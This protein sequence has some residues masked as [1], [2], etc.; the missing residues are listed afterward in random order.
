MNEPSSRSRGRPRSIDRTAALDAAVEA[1]WVRGYDGAS[2]TDLTT[3]MALSRPSLYAAYGDKSDLFAAALDRYLET[4]GGAP[5]RAFEA[6]ADDAA[7]VR[8]FLATSAEGNT[9]PGASQGCL[10]A[11]CAAT[12][13]G[14]DAGLRAKLG[15]MMTATRAR[16]AV[17]LGEVRAGLLLDMMN[18]QAVMART[19]AGRHAVLRDLDARV[20]AVME[21]G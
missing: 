5:M 12:A 21:A 17:R 15:A 20:R 6:E 1:F 4:I 7:A 9:R 16:L 8:A 13:A 10:I 11:C 14:T 18:A 2:L 19:G 3:A